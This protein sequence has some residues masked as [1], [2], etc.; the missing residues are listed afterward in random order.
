[1]NLN[2]KWLHKWRVTLTPKILSTPSI[3]MSKFNRRSAYACNWRLRPLLFPHQEV[4]LVE[5]KY[6]TTQTSWRSILR[7]NI[8]IYINEHH[9]FQLKN[10]DWWIIDRSYLI[11]KYLIFIFI[12]IFIFQ[13]KISINHTTL[14]F[15]Y[16]I[17]IFVKLIESI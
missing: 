3:V 17:F 4:L 8:Y 2:K 11:Y 16:K 9:W 15:Q 13:Y 5:V 1:M 10:L 12:F 14:H 7:M 6:T